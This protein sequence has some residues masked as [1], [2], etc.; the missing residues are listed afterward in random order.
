M[1][2]NNKKIWFRRKTYGFGWTPVSW[3]GWV[4][5]FVWILVFLSLFSKIDH[6]GGKNI[7]FM[8]VMVVILLYVSYKKGESPRWQWGKRNKGTDDKK[9]D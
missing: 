5:L 1:E 7:L 2:N 8:V 3:Q 9:I 4:F 6:E